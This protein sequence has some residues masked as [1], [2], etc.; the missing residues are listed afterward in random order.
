[1]RK[2]LFAVVAVFGVGIA[3]SVGYSLVQN[4]NQAAEQPKA[5]ASKIVKVVVYPHNALVTREVDVPAGVGVAELVVAELPAQVVSSSLYSEGT[6][7]IRVL[8]TRFRTR[9]VERDAREEVRKAEEEKVK[10][11]TQMEKLDGDIRAVEENMKM[12]TKLENFTSVTSVSTTEKGG[13]NGETVIN[14]AKYVMEQR[15]AKAKELVGLKQQV[16]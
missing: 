16:K 14:M 10:I 11:E 12:L 1:M 13:L 9:Q 3:S 2:C 8:S 15:A 4:N 7:G 5:A 6:N